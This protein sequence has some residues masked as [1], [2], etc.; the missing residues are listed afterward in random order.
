MQRIVKASIN[1]RRQIFQTVAAKMHISQE[2]VEKDFWVCRTL[3]NIF[4]NENLRKILRFK[5]GTS[6]SKVFHLI[7]RFSEDIDLILDWRCV[8]DENPLLSRSN[9]KQDNF[10][11]NI[12]EISGK[13]ISGILLQMIAVV[14]D[15]ECSIKPDERDN[16]V[17][18]L[19]YPKTFSAR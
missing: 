19:E 10:N 15:S 4:Q 11:K 1:E 17:L 18:L 13:Y 8:T 7:Q 6:L 14:I 12:Q 3:Q 5:G 2:M 9:T 16:H